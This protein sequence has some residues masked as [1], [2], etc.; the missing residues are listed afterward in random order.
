MPAPIS[1]AAARAILARETAETFADC[2]VISGPGLAPYRFT[3]NNEPI[4]RTEGVFKPLSF[5]VEEPDD[6][7]QLNATMTVRVDNVDRA[8]VRA[9][10]EYPDVPECRFETV[11]VS[12]PNRVVHGP[13]EFAIRAAD[14]DQLWVTLNCGHE[15]NFLN[16]GFPKDNYGPINSPGMYV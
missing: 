9:L 8:I 12:D 1:Q 15:E 10:K 14:A 5:H 6:S 2:L 16:S 4:V 11:L 7:D 3:L 13:Y